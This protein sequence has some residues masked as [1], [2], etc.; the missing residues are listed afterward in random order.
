MN[1]PFE[2]TICALATPH[3]MGA[4]AVIR[5]SGPDA[6]AIADRVF[7]T[8]KGTRLADSPGYRMY[9]GQLLDAQDR[10]LDHVVASVFRAPHSFTG[11]DSVEF[12]CHGAL[13]IQ[14]AALQSLIAHGAVMA[15]P[16]AFSQRA[17]LNGK[18]DLT[19]VE[20][21][22]D[23][24][25]SE[26][27]GAHRLALAQLRGGFSQEL[28]QLRADLL[29]AASLLELELD[30]SDQDVEFVDRAE[31]LALLAQLLERVTYL[32]DSF[33][34][35]NAIKNGIP[36]ALVGAVNAG[37]STLLNA[38]LGEE[39]AIVSNIPG[40]TR[41]T[42]EDTLTLSGTTYRFI[43]TAGLRLSDAP[44]LDPLS[45]A[46]THPLD[47]A[48]AGADPIEQMG[49]QRSLTQLKTAKIILVLLDATRPETHAPTLRAVQQFRNEKESDIILV[50][51]KIDIS[52]NTSVICCN[53]YVTSSISAK[54]RIG[55]EELKNSITHITQSR[56]K[57][58][59]SGTQTLLT[60]LRHY[61]ELLQAKEALERVRDGLSQ[62]LPVPTDL[63]TPDLRQALFHIGAITGQ[64]TT[65]EILSNI[66]SHF[67][68]GK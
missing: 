14:E 24:I 50:Y 13:Y 5:L 1:A 30:F 38:L 60:N 18:M 6:L 62:P 66:F 51:N 8:S 29:R 61:Q 65:D 34:V 21:V 26:S 25:A 42:I 58:A 12:S 33:Q 9:V 17:F 41:D 15:G 39:R 40:T 53:D 22:A 48:Q 7:T 56:V 55:I 68:I 47:P 57:T 46:E 45:S 28:A 36:V 27:E 16:G 64:I 20:A 67:C 3:A 11:E 43:D 54:Q 52:S 37:K 35:G 31:L 32:C 63:L 23:L 2:T 59:L 49:I 44:G 4:L 19:Q 10:L